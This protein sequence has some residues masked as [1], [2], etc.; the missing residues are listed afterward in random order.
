[1]DKGINIIK[2]IDDY[3]SGELS[4]EHKAEFEKRI[5]EEK[6]VQNDVAI[7]KNVIDGVEGHAFK[8]MIK[9]IHQKLSHPES[10]QE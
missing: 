2:E 7:T 9:T 8:E 6:D 1:M 5:R 10:R 4:A 3:L